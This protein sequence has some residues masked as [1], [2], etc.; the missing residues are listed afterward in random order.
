MNRKVFTTFVSAKEKAT[1]SNCMKI[2]GL[3]KVFNFH[4]FKSN[5]RNESL[6]KGFGIWSDDAPFDETNYRDYLW[7]PGENI[8]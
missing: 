4:L 7:Q 5:N 3:H 2:S 1:I 6:T 8:W